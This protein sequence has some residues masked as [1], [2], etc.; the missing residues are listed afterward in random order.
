MA[1]QH[2]ETSTADLTNCAPCGTD[3]SDSRLTPQGQSRASRG[4]VRLTLS[5]PKTVPMT[6]DEYEQTVH[7]FGSMIAR[8]RAADKRD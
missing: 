5:E 2:G 8:W 4:A 6:E 7:A 1:K 3:Q